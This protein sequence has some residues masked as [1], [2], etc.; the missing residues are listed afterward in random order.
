MRSDSSPTPPS[1]SGDA[2]SR[3]TKHQRVVPIDATSDASLRRL[4]ASEPD[5]G[6]QIAKRPSFDGREASAL[7]RSEHEPN[8]TKTVLPPPVVASRFGWRNVSLALLAVVVLAQGGLM[9]FWMYSGGAA[10]VASDS[11]SVTVTSEPVGSPVTI[12]GSAS[13][14]T[15]LTVSLAAGSHSIAVGAGAQLRTQTLTISRGGDASMHV[16]LRRR[17]GVRRKC[18]HRWIANRH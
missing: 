8:P 1:D 16:E 5:P 7:F 13:G 18:G 9:A 12:D 4:F 10:A 2:K 17:A 11:G 3:E 6:G 15:P 14:V